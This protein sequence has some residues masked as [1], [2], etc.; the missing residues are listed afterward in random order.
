MLFKVWFS[1]VTNAYAQASFTA[2]V[3]DPLASF[4]ATKLENDKNSF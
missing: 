2:A 4:V 1:P 3:T